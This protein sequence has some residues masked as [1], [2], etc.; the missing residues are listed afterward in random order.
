[1]FRSDEGRGYRRY[2]S[3]N[4]KQ[5]L[6]RKYP[7]KETSRTTSWIHKEERANLVNWNILVTRGKESKSDS[8]S[9]GE[10]NGTSLNSI[11]IVEGCGAMLIQL[12]V[13]DEA[14]GM[15]HHSRWKSCNRKQIHFKVVS[16]VERDTWNPFWICEDHLVRLNI[17]EQP[18]VNQY[19]EGKVK[20]TPGGEW[21]RT[22]NRKFTSS[23]RAT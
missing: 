16:Q 20:R 13:L 3:G 19:R 11:I 21:N 23:R 7:N 9:S 18:I 15:L 22:W 1:M 10:R 2:V 4:W 12:K 8:L 14:A 6:I 5:V 17:P